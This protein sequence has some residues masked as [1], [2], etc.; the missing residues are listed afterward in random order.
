M[1]KRARLTLI[2]FCAAG[3][4]TP[5]AGGGFGGGLTDAGAVDEAPTDSGGAPLDR[6]SVSDAG[7][8]LVFV[9]SCAREVT[10]A[11]MS[12]RTCTEFEPVASDAAARTATAQA[13][14]RQ[15][16][17]AGI[18]ATWSTER[19]PRAG[20]VGGCVIGTRERGLTT[21]WVYYDWPEGR[22]NC[23]ASG[24]TWVMP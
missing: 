8:G 9:G 24:F 11:G 2:L 22:R 4:G 7:S 16:Q 13:S 21:D 15:L 3:C 10:K 12:R 20:L 1:M 5:V 19:C 23:V 14:C 6:A 17:D 18:M